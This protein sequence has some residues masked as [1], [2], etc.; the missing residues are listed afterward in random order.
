MLYPDKFTSFNMTSL[1]K[2]FYQDF[3][4]VT[5]SDDD[6]KTIMSNQTI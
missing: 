2:E 1:T 3:Y 4:H 5:L 6:V